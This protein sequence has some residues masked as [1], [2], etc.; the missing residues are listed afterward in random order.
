M[1]G[2]EKVDV[3]VDPPADH[4]PR[5]PH[6]QAL[7]IEAPTLLTFGEHDQCTSTRFASPITSR[8]PDAELVVFDGC[9]H[10]PIYQDVE[11]FNSRTLA[12][13]RQHYL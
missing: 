7:P 1:G 4:E 11:G 12:F 13:L 5:H 3:D 6:S 2:E 9:A 8:I 10:A